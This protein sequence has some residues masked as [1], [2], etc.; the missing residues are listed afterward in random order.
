MRGGGIKEERLGEE[1]QSV[2][3]KERQDR[4][5]EESLP[6]GPCVANRNTAHGTMCHSTFCQQVNTF[7]SK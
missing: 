1:R 5:E 3:Q 6:S 4:G 7:I 2:S